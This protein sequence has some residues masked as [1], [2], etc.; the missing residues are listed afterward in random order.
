[1]PGGCYSASRRLTSPRRPRNSKSATSTRRSSGGSWRTASMTARTPVRTRNARLSAVHAL[2]RYAA[3][4]HPEQAAVI[5]RVLAIPPKRGP[6]RLVTFLSDVEVDALLAAPDRATWT[7]RR[8]HTLLALA[9]QTGLRVSE[10]TGLRSV[11]LHLACGAHVNCLGKGRKQRITPL[12]KPMAAALRT[13]LTE[14]AGVPDAPVFPTRTGRPLSRD[15]IAQRLATHVATAALACHPSAK[16]PSPHRAHRAPR[17]PAPRPRRVRP[18]RSVPVPQDTSHDE[19]QRYRLTF[20]TRGA[21]NGSRRGATAA[22]MSERAR[23]SA[24][25][26]G[27]V[28]GSGSRTSTANC[29]RQPRHSA[30]TVS[31]RSGDAVGRCAPSSLRLLTSPPPS[32]RCRPSPPSRTSGGHRRCPAPR[33]PPRLEPGL[34]R[35]STRSGSS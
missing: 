15:A 32:A 21:S 1:M 12:T 16:R 34:H 3:L 28:A 8:D 22:S 14:R 7:G 18:A 17:R 29:V 24:P 9:I 5:A 11:D 19:T 20:R 27:H 4:E 25:Q 31:R 23:T 13:W 35:C 10:L 6:R 33:K 26:S 2:F 30:A